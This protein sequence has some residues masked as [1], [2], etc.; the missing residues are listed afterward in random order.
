MR[1][2]LLLIV[3]FLSLVIAE[4]A[5]GQVLMDENFNYTAGDS[6]GAHGWVWNTGTTNTILVATPGLT[7][8]VT[9]FQALEIPAELKITEMMHTSRQIQH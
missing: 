5:S 1:R 6:I 3:A 9:R 8:A 4:K 2:T 7:Y